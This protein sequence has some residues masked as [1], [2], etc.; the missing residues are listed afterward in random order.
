LRRAAAKRVELGLHDFGYRSVH[1]IAKLKQGQ[2][3]S[4]QYQPLRDNWFEIQIR[5][6]L[7]HAWA[8]IE[9]EVVYK[10]GVDFPDEVKR[11]FAR[12]AGS[13]ELL[14]NEFL[15]LR[16]ARESL[17]ERYCAI[18]AQKGEQRRPAI[19]ALCDDAFTLRR[20]SRLIR[21]HNAAR[22]P[23]GASLKQVGAYLEGVVAF[24]QGASA[25]HAAMDD[26]ALAVAAVTMPTPPSALAAALPATGLAHTNLV[27]TTDAMNR[28]ADDAVERLTVMTPFVNEEG[29]NYA[30]GL[31]RR[32]RAKRRYLIVRPCAT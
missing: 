29:L 26:E 4:G 2:V 12:L 17:I 15:A 20:V 14:D 32:S 3:L 1:L 8:E 11:R 5:S 24:L 6:I 21:V 18:Y 9:H 25:M 16:E 22:K 27:A 7:E 23:A 31:F 10:S 19:V 30:I 28:V 13:L